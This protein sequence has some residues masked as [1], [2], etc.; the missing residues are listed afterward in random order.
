MARLSCAICSDSATEIGRPYAGWR[1]G[2]P[3]S[4]LWPV[5]GAWH[6]GRVRPFGLCAPR[7]TPVGGDQLGLAR[8]A[9]RLQEILCTDGLSNVVPNERL[10]LVF[11]GRSDLDATVA[12]LMSIASAR[13]ATDDVT[14]ILVRWGEPHDADASNQPAAR[15][16]L[17]LR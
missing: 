5:R 10:A 13:G 15:V 17:A 2:A 1:D 16:A 7:W 6:G 9:E 12:V 11:A 4:A 8:D 3:R 14:C